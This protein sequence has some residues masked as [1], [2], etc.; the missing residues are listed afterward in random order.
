MEIK[1]MQIEFNNRP[2]NKDILYVAVSLRGGNATRDYIIDGNTHFVSN[3]AFYNILFNYY[4]NMNEVTGLHFDVQRAVS[5][6]SFNRNK[7]EL[8]PVLREVLCSLFNHEY[9]ED[10]FQ[11]AKQQAKDAF[12]L[13]YKDGAFRS[14]YKAFE[15]SELNKCFTLK[16]LIDDIENIDFEKF[17]ACANAL[18][19][20]ENISVY[21]LGDTNDLDFEG[22]KF[23]D[24]LETFLHDVRIA[25][26]GYNPYLRQ[27][28][29]VINVAREDC[30]LIVEAIDFFN[31]DVTNFTKFLIAELLAELIPICDKD[32][33]VDS[34]DSSIMFFCEELCSYKDAVLSYDIN[35]YMIAHESLL[36]KYAAL[37]ENNP[38][39]FAIKAAS[40]MS[41]GIYVDQY[42][43]FLDKCTYEMFIE[44]CEKADYK[45]TEAQIVLRKEPR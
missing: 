28:A 19:V 22:M 33:W 4:R 35:K 43:D 1:K 16:T 18:L 29:Y 9:S 8:I 40:L 20:S 11:E 34:L 23:D 30:N 25:S 37:L 42:I 10:I 3:Y 12:I 7:A 39:H 17:C 5:T 13:R 44:I 36:N 21:L 24:C 31:E 45:I 38:E 2:Y 27:E 26:R 15:F 6:I 32:V 14:R 41:I